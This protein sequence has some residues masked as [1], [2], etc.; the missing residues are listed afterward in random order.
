[1]A[2]TSRGLSKAT[3]NQSKVWLVGQLLSKLNQ[4]TLPSIG[5]VLRLFF[6]YKNEEKKIIRESATLAACEVIHLWEKVSIPIQLKKHVIS[7]IEKL[8]KEWQNLKKIRK[9]RKNDQKH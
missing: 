5:E 9:T 1:M 2:S 4:S 7:K 6:Y 3:R 8:F